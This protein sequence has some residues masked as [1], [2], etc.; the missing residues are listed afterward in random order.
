MCVYPIQE[1]LRRELV[2]LV[3]GDVA[4]DE[5]WGSTIASTEAIFAYLARDLRPQRILLLGEVGG[6]YARDPRLDPDARFIP[7]VHASRLEESETAL[8]GSHAVDVTGGMRSKV[9]SMIDL[10]HDLPD[11]CVRVFSG[12]TPGLLEHALVDPRFSVGTLIVA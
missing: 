11:L 10:V 12:L 7:L 5:S 1:V 6:V 2:P 4:V 8:G 3:Y 9:H